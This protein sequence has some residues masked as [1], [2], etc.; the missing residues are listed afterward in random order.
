MNTQITATRRLEEEISNPGAP[1]RGY[2]VPPLQ[3]DANDVQ[4]PVNPPP[5][6]D[7]EIRASFLQIVEAITTQAQYVTTQAQAMTA[8]FDREVVPRANQHVGTMA[9]RLIDFTRMNPPN[10]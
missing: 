8:Q 10:F 5:L 9:S 7:G 3:E 1:P 6:T 2:Q 4:A